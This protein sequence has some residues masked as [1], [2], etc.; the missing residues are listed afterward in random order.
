MA[1]K[2]YCAPGIRPPTVE[3][4]RES[5]QRVGLQLSDEELA[6]AAKRFSQQVPS[7]TTVAQLTEPACLPVK[8]PRTPGY[9]PSAAENRHNAWFWKTDIQGASSGPL[10]GKTVVIKD[11]VAVAGVPMTNG[12]RIFEGYIPE[13][14]ASVISRILDA[15]G[16]IT[17]KAMCEDLCFS[18][19]S[20]KN[21]KG[22]VR[23]PVD[24]SRISGG[25]SSGSA[26]LV[27]LGE[28]DLAI[29]GD[30]GGSI[31]IP[32][33]LCGIVGLKPTFGL[34][35]YTGATSIE[36]SIDHLGPMGRS[37]KDVA[38]LLQVIAG[39][40]QL[41]FRQPTHMEIPDYV[42]E[43]E[44]SV[45]GLK[46]GFLEEGFKSAK[47]EVA[48]LVGSMRNVFQSIGVE[49]KDVS[50]PEH[51]LALCLWS[52]LITDGVQNT[53]LNEM[54]G[55]GFRG[56]YPSS[57]GEHFR[58]GW[59]TM[60]N[61][62]PPHI[63]QQALLG[64][65]I[66][67]NYGNQFYNKAQN[68]CPS[69]TKAYDDVLTDNV[70]VIFMPTCPIT[71]PK[72]PS[73]DCDPAGSEVGSHGAECCINTAQFNYT[74]H[75]AL[76]LNVGYI[77]GLPVGGMLVSKKFDEATLLRLAYGLEQALAAQK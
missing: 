34:V 66:K 6:N 10:H 43:L 9:R 33:T 21:V 15:G 24:P 4:L 54:N 67:H 56:F 38:T 36:P 32:S 12:S 46:V 49:V 76:S 75:P 22:P 35:P 41:D 11:N 68:L 40:D 19:S 44:K 65:Y 1:G 57:M 5:A 29:G 64:D 60:V 74:G 25:S 62:L 47:D 26:V 55:S 39:P 8:Y 28:A 27:G 73:S 48:S 23:N 37:V 53:L 70:D 72:I 63:K 51:G 13:F 20:I 14:D 18:G 59:K 31:R 16:Q 69:I 71:A 61:S 45:A 7:Y 42:K 77:E 52:V 2:E 58:R 3:S 17:G 30:Q 50:V